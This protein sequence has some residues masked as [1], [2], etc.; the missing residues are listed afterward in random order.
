[1]QLTS[2]TKALLETTKILKKYVYFKDSSSYL[3]LALFILLTY[4][5]KNFD[6][7]P[8]LLITGPYGSGKTLILEILN[9]LC[10]RPLLASQISRAAFYDVIHRLQGTLLI[11]EAEGLSKRYQSDFDMAILLH[12]YKAGGFVVKVDA[13]KRK[14]VKFRCFS[15]KVIANIGGIYSKQLRSRCIILKT[16]EMEG[17]N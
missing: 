4:C 10:F 7:V 2:L 8:Y 5:F 3:I 16:T 17:G 15:P 12:G 11:D 14:H 1:M 6:T 9:S 13:N